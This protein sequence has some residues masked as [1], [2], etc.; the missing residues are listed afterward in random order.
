MFSKVKGFS[1]VGIEA[2]PIEIEVDITAGL[3]QVAVVG[4]PDNTVKESKDRI[5]SAIKNSGYK[6]PSQRI[7][8]NLAPADL[9]K[10]GSCL[11]LAIAIGILAASGLVNENNLAKYACIGELSLDGSLRPVKGALPIAM[12][13]AKR[14]HLALVVPK[15]N[16][17]EA[18][19][20]NKIRVYPAANLQEVINFL[21]EQTVIKQAESDIKKLLKETSDYPFDFSEVK[22]QQQIKRGLEVS[23]A[24]SHNCLL[25][26]PPGSGKT[27]LSRRIPSIMPDMS[28]QEALETTT[29]HSVLGLVPKDKGLIVH[30]PFRSPHHTSSDIALVGGGTIPRPGEISLAHNGVLFMDELPEFHR[31]VLEALRQPMEDGFVNVSRASQSLRFPSKFMLVAAMNP[32]PCGYY[33]DPKKA[34]RCTTPKIQKYLSKIS[35]PLLDR[36]DIHLEVAGLPYKEL[37]AEQPAESSKDIKARVNA[38]RKIQLERFDSERIY[39]NS[40][41]NQKQLKKYCQLDNESRD[42]LK[43]AIEQLG[44]SARS[45]DKILKVSRTIADLAGCRE[46]NSGHV[47][48]AIQYR[49]LDRELW[50]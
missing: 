29:V 25:I 10:E 4:L 2:Y 42:L 12:N 46:I 45:Y 49:G 23:V 7:T 32:C 27:M 24:G 26:G 11:D 17:L 18:A 43:M 37:T 3:P 38:A 5:R 35:G 41:M 31:N 19:V 9:K 40:Q 14:G 50:T 48:E 22:G 28:L 15:A 8:I 6:Y 20:V 16:A 21:S 13:M 44:F 47:A 33:T 30:R 34:C 39:A 36:I 1:V